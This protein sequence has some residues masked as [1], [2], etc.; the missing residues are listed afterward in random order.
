MACGARSVSLG[1]TQICSAPSFS[2]S[3]CDI[4]APSPG[5]INVDGNHH[6]IDS[7]VPSPGNNAFPSHALAR[8][9]D[10]TTPQ[11]EHIHFWSPNLSTDDGG[12]QQQAVSIANNGWN[13]DVSIT[14]SAWDLASQEFDQSFSD[15][16]PGFGQRFTHA[17]SSPDFPLTIVDDQ[18]D[19]NFQTPGFGVYSN[20]VVM[21]NDFANFNSSRWDDLT[22]LDA[23]P[24]MT[25]FNQLSLPTISSIPAAPALHTNATS[26]FTAPAALRPIARSVASRHSSVNA[27]T[28]TCDYS[29]CGHI[30]SR[31]GD[32]VRH[33][34]QHGVPQHPCPVHGCNRRGSRAFYR[35]DKLRDHQRKKHRM[36]I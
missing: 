24:T 30:F 21:P 25:S 8:L 12:L 29:G 13:P 31:I 6:Y 28:H 26:M 23:Q 1:P 7:L 16:A 36:T 20:D 15:L 2:L 4:V 35:A 11:D 5:F 3:P 10:V 14:P 33:R 27:N 9:V 32:F 22:A 18:S 17:L 19:P 34:K